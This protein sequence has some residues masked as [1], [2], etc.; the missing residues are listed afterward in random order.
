MEGLADA[1]DVILGRV[2]VLE[3]E[4]QCEGGHNT[5]ELT[6][7]GSCGRGVRLRSSCPILR[8]DSSSSSE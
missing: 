7:C 3:K 5:A 2:A 8:P 4:L 6:C 1:L